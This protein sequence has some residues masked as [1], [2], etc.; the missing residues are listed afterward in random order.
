MLFKLRSGVKQN[1]SDM[2]KLTLIN[3]LFNQGLDLTCMYSCDDETKTTRNERGLRDCAAN[4]KLNG[5]PTWTPKSTYKR[6]EIVRI[7]RNVRGVTR[8]SYHLAK[9][10]IP[11]QQI[12]PT[13]KI[14]NNSFWSRCITRKGQEPAIKGVSYLKTLYEFMIKHCQNC[15]IGRPGP[16]TNSISAD[17]NIYPSGTDTSDSTKSIKSVP[18]RTDDNEITF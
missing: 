1:S 7:I 11:A 12:S 10:D 18:L 4:W 15:S 13:S 17:T 8:A 14:T 5:A 6:G 3:Y 9:K 16:N 2:I